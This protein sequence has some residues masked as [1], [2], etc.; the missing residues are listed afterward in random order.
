MLASASSSISKLSQ[1]NGSD[2]EL[3]W[4]QE[5]SQVGYRLFFTPSSSVNPAGTFVQKHASPVAVLEVANQR[6]R[7]AV[8][9]H[10]ERPSV[11]SL[12]PT[13]SNRYQKLQP[14]IVSDDEFVTCTC[15]VNRHR[16][17]ST[18]YRCSLPHRIV[19]RSCCDKIGEA[20]QPL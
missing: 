6:F 7:R 13:L 4:K 1:E 19:S 11:V 12:S 20:L 9:I 15:C 3:R 14:S 17:P 5:G 16:S 2:T 10:T 18:P 8:W